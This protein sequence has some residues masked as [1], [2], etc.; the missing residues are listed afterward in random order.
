MDD[1]TFKRGAEGELAGFFSENGI[2]ASLWS[3]DN[4][5]RNTHG[6]EFRPQQLRMAEAVGNAIAEGRHLLVEAGTGVGKSMAYLL[7]FAIY[8]IREKKRAVISTYTKTLQEQLIKKDLPFLKNALYDIKYALC[9]GGQNYLCLRRLNSCYEHDLFDSEGEARQIARINNWSKRTGNGLCSEL[10]F[11]PGEDAWGKVCRESYSCMGKRCRYHRECFYGK[12]RQEQERADILVVNHHLYFSDI[13]SGGNVLPAFDAVVFDEAHMLEDVATSYF[14]VEVNNR[15]LDRYLDSIAHARSGKGLLARIA[16][17]NPA[18]AADIRAR[19]DAARNCAKTLFSEVSDFLSKGGDV[20]R[21][22]A[23]NFVYNH[24]KDP[25]TDVC[26]RLSEMLDGADAEEDR[27]EIKAAAARG[28]AI[29]QSLEAVINMSLDGYVYWAESEARFRRARYGLC[30]APVDISGDFR[31]KVLD[32]LDTAVFTSATLSVSGDFSF[33]RRQLGIDRADEL[34]LDSPFDYNEQAV[35]YIPEGIPDPNLQ[36]EEYLGRV[37]REISGIIE[38][39]RGKTFILFTSYDMMDKAFDAV[40]SKA[41]DSSTGERNPL[42]GLI[43]MKQGQLP[44]Y[45]LLERFKEADNAVLFGTTTFWQGVD[46]PGRDLECVIITR[47]PF[48]APDEPVIEAKMERL[49]SQSRNPFAEYQLPQAIMMFRQGFGR[50]IRTR[51]DTGMVAVLDP[52]VRTKYYGRYFLG[53]IPKCRSVS[54]VEEAAGFLSCEK[55]ADSEQTEART[56]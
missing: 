33:I 10:D 53:S 41:A 48:A 52:R 34:A 15:Q 17:Y 21:I 51:H 31:G 37:V 42:A 8:A 43:L 56:V 46:V 45:M 28:E 12:A 19:L 32:S 38:I 36:P 49:R 29:N 26:L 44:R 11:L 54:R 30:A 35:L 13:V 39:T 2:F 1:T 40:S 20:R 5:P 3:G 27:T 6:Y 25:L 50:L 9:M 18:K 24:V 16:K 23:A 7:P 14:G 47:L 22:R 4:N 55:G